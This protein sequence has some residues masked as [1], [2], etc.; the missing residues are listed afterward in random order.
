MILGYAR[1]STLD[2]NLDMQI[3][4]LEKA[5]CERVITDKVKSEKESR[6]GLDQVLTMLRSGDTLVVWKL[7]RLGRTL[8][9]LVNL[10]DSFSK[11]NI[12]FRSLQESIDTT[13]P[14][15]K[16]IFHTI[17]AIAEFE[18]DMI[19]TRTRSGLAAARARGRLGGRPPA[20]T[21]GKVKTAIAMYNTGCTVDEI[22]SEMGISRST[23]YK[24][25][26]GTGNERK[27]GGDRA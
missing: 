9:H 19:R 27:T 11:K 26:R 21:T 23:F 25:I 18:R 1:V 5:G 24:Y 10:I 3:D 4:A 22:C 15:G 14:V 12:Q 2:Q 8:R 16:L 7:D 17:S 20:L 13:T 6:P